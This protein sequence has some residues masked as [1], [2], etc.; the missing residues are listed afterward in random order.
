MPELSHD[1]ALKHVLHDEIVE[2]LDVIIE[3][4]KMQN[5]TEMFDPQ[6]SSDKPADVKPIKPLM[7]HE[8][9]ERFAPFLERELE[10]RG[11]LRPKPTDDESSASQ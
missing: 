4:L 2:R 1:D 8:Q 7:T 5:R 9:A 10:K 3:L 11:L 6:E